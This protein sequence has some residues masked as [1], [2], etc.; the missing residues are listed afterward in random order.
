MQLNP[1]QIRQ[2]LI[3]SCLRG[4]ALYGPLSSG[5]RAALRAD[6]QIS[7]HIDLLGVCG[8]YILTN[9]EELLKY[10]PLNKLLAN[11]LTKEMEIAT[12]LSKQIWFDF[13]CCGMFATY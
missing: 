7:N 8:F 3:Q 5:G 11:W 2:K 1:Q 9:D 4:D 13:G 6:P 10:Y 12:G